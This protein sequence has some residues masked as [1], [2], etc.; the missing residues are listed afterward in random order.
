MIFTAVAICRVMNLGNF[1]GRRTTNGRLRKKEMGSDDDDERRLCARDRRLAAVHEAGHLVIARHFRLITA[2]ARIFPSRGTSDSEKLWV[3]NF[4]FSRLMLAGKRHPRY[5]PAPP[6]VL[7]AVAGGW[8]GGGI[9][10]A[11]DATGRNHRQ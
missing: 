2:S 5:D 3:G 7:R 6:N 10:L 4:S 9:L 8:K 1:L 11:E